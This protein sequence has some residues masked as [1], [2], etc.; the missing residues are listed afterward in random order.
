[1]NEGKG[2]KNNNSVK[3]RVDMDGDEISDDE[4]DISSS[5]DEEV[6]DRS[7]YILTRLGNAEA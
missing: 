6:S 3:R 7:I 4:F 5:D 1:M 2:K